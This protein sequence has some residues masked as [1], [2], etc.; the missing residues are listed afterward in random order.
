MECNQ[1][2]LENKIYI[3]AFTNSTKITIVFGL[4]VNKRR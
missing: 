3:N 2:V 4:D 1:L